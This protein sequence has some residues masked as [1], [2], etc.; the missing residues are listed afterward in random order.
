M[1]DVCVVGGGPAGMAVAARAAKN[2]HAVTLVDAAG[3]LGGRLRTQ[4]ESG[5]LVE[6]GAAD[7]LLPATLRDL[8]RKTG[9]P[10]ERELGLTMVEGDRDH[11]ELAGLDHLAIPLT[12]R[13]AQQEAVSEAAGQDA[14]RI[15][16]GAVD[17]AGEVWTARHGDWETLPHTTRD[18]FRL[19]RSEAGSML[20]PILRHAASAAGATHASVPGVV[21]S[22]TYLEQALGIWRPEGGS[23]ALVESLFTRLRLREVNVKSGNRV[24]GLLARADGTVGGIRT[25]AGNQHADVVV[26]TVGVPELRTILQHITHVRGLRSIRYRL[27]FV[28]AAPVPRVT[29]ASV[30]QGSAPTA[31]ETVFHRQSA[32]VRRHEEGADGAVPLTILRYG[33]S[34]RLPLD[35]ASTKEI[36]QAPFAFGPALASVRRMGLLPHIH[37]QVPGLMVAGPSTHLAGLLSTELLSAA[38]AA[39]ALG[40]AG[41]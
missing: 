20:S 36:S 1:A 6:S 30:D 8:Y 35:A 10:L 15:W 18:T 14:A 26:L 23:A 25:A 31:F 17:R 37:G 33:P 40:R 32:V 22:R 4:L 7:M 29:L 12:G 27:R 21:A 5:E 11:R 13:G 9:R 24:T 34:P 41:R 28:R 19:T 3:H 39:D 2:G 16:T 38:I